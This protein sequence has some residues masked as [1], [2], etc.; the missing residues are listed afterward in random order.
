V[1]KS[2]IGATALVVSAFVVEDWIDVEQNAWF[3]VTSEDPDHPVECAFNLYTDKTAGWR[4]GN[5]PDRK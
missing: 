2:V 3:D 5:A 1:R 4:A